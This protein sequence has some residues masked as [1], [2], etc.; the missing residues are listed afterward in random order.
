MKKGILAIIG[1]CVWG[2]LLMLQGTPKVT[3]DIAAEAVQA[4]HPQAEVEDVTNTQDGTRTAYKVAYYENG[5]AG[6]AEVADNGQ[7]AA[8]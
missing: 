3:A 6:V 2:G 5:K 7:L 4:M 8:R 1:L